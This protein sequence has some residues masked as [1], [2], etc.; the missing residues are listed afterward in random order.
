MSI[1]NEPAVG[2]GVQQ[3]GI[4]C[5]LRAIVSLQARLVAAQSSLLRRVARRMA[6][7]VLDKKCVFV[8]GTGHPHMLAEEAFCR[9]GRLA[10]V[11]PIFHPGLMLHESIP[12]WRSKPRGCCRRNAAERRSLSAR[13]CP[14][15]WNTTLQCRSA[16]KACRSCKIC[17]PLSRLEP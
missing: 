12:A 11:V 9:A 4:D 2:L 1:A 6:Q 7:T 15:G 3:D 5:Y 14:A 16:G 17:C 13:T 8:V 10:S